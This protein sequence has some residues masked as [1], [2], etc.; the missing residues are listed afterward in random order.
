MHLDCA[1]DSEETRTILF[2]F[3][4]I[5]KIS[6]NKRRS[7]EEKRNPLGYERW[8]IEPVHSWLG[9]FRAIF[10]RYT[11]YVDHYLSYVQ[12]ASA[13]VALNKI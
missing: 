3:Y 12:F 6:P 1:Y 4:Y 7:K 2:N 9:R 10:T 13:F 11:K 5:H 8:F